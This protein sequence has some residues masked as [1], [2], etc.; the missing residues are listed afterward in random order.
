MGFSLRQAIWL[1]RSNRGF[2]LVEAMVV[3]CIIGALVGFGYS[4]FSSLLQREKARAAATQLMGQLKEARM[5]AM[6][7]HASYAVAVDADK[8]EYTIFRDDSNPANYVRDTYE[9]IIHQVDLDQDFPGVTLSV[10]TIPFRFDTRGMPRKSG[11]FMGTT[12]TLT[13]TG[14]TQCS[15]SISNVGRIDVVT[16]QEL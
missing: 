11:T 9:P 4:G 10:T 13:L 14:K 16:C 1:L 2:T 15:F 12:F 8:H 6:E 5:L 3:V 7:K